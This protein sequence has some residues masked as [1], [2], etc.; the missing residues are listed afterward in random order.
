MDIFFRGGEA[1]EGLAELHEAGESLSAIGRVGNL[2]AH[3]VSTGDVRFR[4]PYTKDL[5]FYLSSAEQGSLRLI[6][7][8]VSGAADQAVAALQRTKARALF[9]RVI[10]RGL[11][12]AA[13]E[14]LIVHDE[15]FHSGTID[16]LA[17]ASEP[18][19]RR[20]HRWVDDDRNIS[21]E[22]DDLEKI[23][24]TQETKEYLEFENVDQSEVAQDVSVAALNVNNRTGRVYFLDLGRTVPFKVI[25]NA[26]AR[27]IPNLAQYLSEYADKTGATVN[28]RFQRVSSADDRLKKI[29][30]S[31]CYPI[32]GL[33]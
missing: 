20:A 16:A 1:T 33:L 17:E 24:F 18:A 4:G 13:E 11:G 28:I 21:L 6:I 15:T 30:I 27:T 3:F 7:K 25:R 14:D 32:E 2:T 26:A 23:D 9:R 10:R 8:E 5:G 29:L 22:F 31:D 12:D 19:L